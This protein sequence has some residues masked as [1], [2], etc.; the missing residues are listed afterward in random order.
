MESCLECCFC[1]VWF[2]FLFILTN[3]V[4]LPRNHGQGRDGGWQR[5]WYRVS[6][7]GEVAKT[8]QRD[9]KAETKKSWNPFCFCF[10]FELCASLFY[11]SVSV[12]G[13]LILSYLPLHEPR[14]TLP[15]HWRQ[16]SLTR[17]PFTVQKTVSRTRGAN[18]SCQLPIP[19]LIW[20]V[21]LQSRAPEVVLSAWDG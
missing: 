7:L 15:E 19:S 1:L 3:L 5:I 2:T 12:S 8:Q 11:L 10:F 14:N 16:A 18:C 20:C 9:K 21:C 17:V 13:S 4:C 6:C